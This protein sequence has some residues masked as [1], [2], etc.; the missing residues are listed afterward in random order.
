MPAAIQF[1][2]LYPRIGKIFRF[3]EKERMYKN[4]GFVTPIRL[5]DIKKSQIALPYNS[6]RLVLKCFLFSHPRKS[7][8]NNQF[9]LMRVEFFYERL[10]DSKLM[11]CD[12]F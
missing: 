7:Y 9:C 1:P 8:I 3:S 11:C 5:P 12:S 2:P 10:I 6:L 4:L